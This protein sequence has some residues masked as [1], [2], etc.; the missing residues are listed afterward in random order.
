MALRF[1]S[2]RQVALVRP[3]ML[4]AIPTLAVPAV[5][6]WLTTEPDWMAA[7][8]CTDRGR[9]LGLKGYACDH[10][11]MV[12]VGVAAIAAFGVIALAWWLISELT[13]LMRIFEVP[14]FGVGE[15]VES[16]G[17]IESVVR[18]AI[19]VLFVW[20]CLGMAA[21]A[22]GVIT[23]FAPTT[24]VGHN[25]GT[26]VAHD[27][28]A[29]AGQDKGT[30]ATQGKNGGKSLRRQQADAEPESSILDQAKLLN[31]NLLE[32]KRQLINHD[33]HLAL[34]DPIRQK[35]AEWDP[36]AAAH[37][38]ATATSILRQTERLG[39][40][41]GDVKTHLAKHGEQF[42]ELDETFRKIAASDFWT[43]APSGSTVA[44]IH[45]QVH[46]LNAKMDEVNQQLAQHE[47]H[48]AILHL[49]QQTLDERSRGV[50]PGNCFDAVM[51][52]AGGATIPA[53]VGAPSAGDRKGR[54][55]SVAMRVVF[56][57]IGRTELS[58]RA[59]NDL[60]RFLGAWN[61]PEYA[62]AVHGSADPQGS[63]DTNKILSL[64]RAKAIEEF[65]RKD[66]PQLPILTP[67]TATNLGEPKSEPYQR[68]ATIRILQP[69]R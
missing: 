26:S 46:R 20:L 23:K 28:G 45:D 57:D 64:Q 53:G 3:W 59:R 63:P 60:E 36:R 18:A 24:S 12:L 34:L 27:K 67:T 5:A 55:R 58:P 54:Y 19:F 25:K 8:D 32:V 38:P 13:G 49:I 10:L 22:V 9:L 39:T 41:L 43:R 6:I 33:Q 15:D 69:C 1:L 30:S 51:A 11:R 17:M 61:S 21:L 50:A 68:V 40:Q 56:F 7:T 62:A 2:R 66:V 14:W 42:A 47:Q 4:L 29:S 31:D 44:S 48:L 52:D 37:W 65:I 16:V 35:L